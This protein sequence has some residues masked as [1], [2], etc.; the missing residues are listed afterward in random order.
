MPPVQD[1]AGSDHIAPGEDPNSEDSDVDTQLDA[2]SEL[3]PAIFSTAGKVAMAIRSPLSMHALT[4]R[5]LKL[6]MAGSCSSSSLVH[7]SLCL[8]EW[9]RS[10]VTCCRCQARVQSGDH[11]QHWD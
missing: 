9:L 4:F 3:T 1:A 2:A 6:L 5:A 7:L 8:A 10:P 11:Q